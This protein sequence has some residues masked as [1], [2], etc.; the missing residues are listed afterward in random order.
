MHKYTS[1]YSEI[2]LELQIALS[3]MLFLERISDNVQWRTGE[4][5]WRKYVWLT[6]ELTQNSHEM[7]VECLI[8]SCYR[9]AY[10]PGVA[11]S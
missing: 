10:G 7:A 1:K 9:L 8:C 3:V 4:R 6:L 11:F 2:I 5:I